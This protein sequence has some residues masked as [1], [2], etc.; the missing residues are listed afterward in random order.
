MNGYFRRKLLKSTEICFSWLVFISF[1]IAL[2][3]RKTNVWDNYSDLRYYDILVS[4]WLINYEG[5]FVRRGLIGQFMWEL[6]HIFS[7]DVRL[8]IGA[9]IIISSI[10]LVT[11]L[12][13]MFKKEGWPILLLPT[14]CCLGYTIFNY[15]G[16]RDLL[17]II[18]SIVIFYLY[19][20]TRSRLEWKYMLLFYL[21]SIIQILIHEASFFYTFFFLI[22]VEFMGKSQYYQLKD[23]IAL[24]V[25]RFSP[26]LITFLLVSLYHGNQEVANN[27]W[28][29][30]KDIFDVHPDG[31]SNETVGSGMQYLVSD[32]LSAAKYHLSVAYKGGLYP[33]Y[34][35]ALL[36]LFNFISVYYMT[37]RINTVNMLIFRPLKMEHVIMSD[38]VLMQFIFMLPMFTIL[39]CDWG[40]TFPYLFITSISLY[41]LFHDSNIIFP[42]FIHKI[43]I[44]IQE[45]ISSI[46]LLRSPFFYL[47][48]V[49]IT[50]IPSFDAPDFSERVHN[51]FQYLFMSSL[52]QFWNI[53][54]SIFN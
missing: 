14:G 42:H 26:I 9:I 41:V 17:S 44:N 31:T 46:C 34:W 47:F 53:L 40:R 32:L 51:N 20:N 45:K 13:R 10:T 23:N 18:L 30:W 50:P 43:S 21:I 24:C 7:F 27:I 19:K 1:A 12:L 48:I 36:C 6:E 28:A 4:D 16:R 25:L 2:L 15:F 37:T 38:I 52:T 5:G 11:I 22:I 54:I 8:F 39:S 35:R 3:Y 33:E 49:F 29:S